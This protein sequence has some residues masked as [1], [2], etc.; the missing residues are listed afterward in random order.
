VLSRRSSTEDKYEQGKHHCTKA[1]LDS[2]QQPAKA[3][4]LEIT[5]AERCV[6]QGGIVDRV[7]NLHRVGRDLYVGNRVIF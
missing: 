1:C 4:G 3:D 5:E 2:G 6:R 7:Q